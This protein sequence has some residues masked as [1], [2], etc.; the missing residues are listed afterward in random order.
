MYYRDK[1]VLNVKVVA[2]PIEMVAW[3]DVKGALHP[4]RFR[5]ADEEGRYR[6]I[7]IDKIINRGT[8]KFAGN[9]MLVYRC[10][11]IFGNEEKVYELKFEISTCKWM[12]FKI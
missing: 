9:P 3:F 1:E 8:E 4:V 10:Q 12:L 11:S 2:K 6:V 5:L 7:K